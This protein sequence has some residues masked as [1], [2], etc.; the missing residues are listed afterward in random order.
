MSTLKKAFSSAVALSMVAIALPVASW[1][2]VGRTVGQA[3]VSDSGEA[4]YTIPISVPS[5]INGLTPALALAYGHRQEEGIAGVGWS[6][7]GLS[8]ISRCGKSFAQDGVSKTVELS[9][10]D[11]FCIDGNQLRL[12]FGSYGVAG[13][14]YRSEV[15]TIAR[16]TANGTAGN[17]PAWFL[18][19]DKSGLVYEYGN[20]TN[21]RIESLAAGWTTT[22]RSWAL[23]KIRD[24]QGNEIVFTYV[25]DGAPYGDYRISTVTYRSNPGQGVAAGYS[26]SFFYGTQPAGDVDVPYAAGAKV[27]DIKRLDRVDILY[28]PT[29][30]VRQY[31]LAYEVALSTAGRS[32]VTSIQECAGAPLQC[33]V[34]TDFTYQNGTSDMTALGA[35]TSSG[36]SIPAGTKALPIDINGDGRT[37]LV[38]PSSNVSGFWHYRLAN[39]TGGYDAV[40]NSGISSINHALAIPIDHNSDGREDILVPFSG[41]TWWAIHGSANPSQALL[42]QVNTSAPAVSTAGNA[43]AVDMDGDG[44][45]DLVWGE[46]VAYQV[47]SGVFVR[48]RLATGNGFATTATVIFDGDGE[49]ELAGPTLFGSGFE[50]HRGKR[51]DANG[52]GMA[53]LAINTV[54][55][56]GTHPN[57]PIWYNYTTVYLGGGAG[58]FSVYNQNPAI[59]LPIDMN[60]D[61]YTD[62]AFK[63]SIGT[64]QIALSTGK[65]FAPVGGGPDLTNYNFNLAVAMDWDGD[66]M[67]DLLIP[68]TSS[69][70]WYYFRSLG[71]SFATAVN[72]G[73]ATSSAT[74][75]FAI[76]SNGDGLD[77]IGYVT[78]AG[79]Y[80]YRA[81]SGVKPDLLA[82][83]T[84]GNGNTITFNYQPL[85]QSTYT[86]YSSATFP[87]QD[88]AGPTYVVSSAVPSTGI[89]SGTY[90]L[91]Y[92]YAGAIMNV[93]GRGLA[94]FDLKTTQDSRNGIKV[95]EYFLRDFPY[96]GRLYKRQMTQSNDTMIQEVTNTWQAIVGGTG[97]QNYHF[98]YV[99]QSLEKN[100][101]A[102]GTYNGAQLNEISTTTVVD[103]YGTPTS[104]TKVTTEM[105][106]ANGAQAGAIFTEQV[107]NS[108]ITDNVTT[109][110][111]GKVGQTDWINSHSQAYGSQITRTVTR[112]WETSSYCR[113]L[114]EVTEPAS[115]TYKVTRGVGYDAFGNVNSETVTGVNMTAR[116]TTTNWGTTGQFP[117]T[118]TNPLSQVTTLGWDAAKAVQTSTT[119]PNG[120]VVSSLYDEFGRKTRDTRVDGTYTT[121][122]L[123]A[124]TSGNSYCGTSYSR[125]KTKLR[126]LA[127]NTAGTEIR[128]DDSF[129]DKM[130]RPVQSERQTLGGAVSRVR[131]IYDTLGRVSQ[132]SAP[133]F[134]VTPA[135]NSTTTYDLLNRPTQISRPIDVGNPALQYTITDYFGLTTTTTDAE[136]KISTKVSDALGRVYRS[137]D[138][139]GYY[140]QFE[141]DAF[142]SVR[143]VSDAAGN[144]L[145]Q[146][147]Y[148][149]GIEAHRLSSDDMDMGA[150]T[151][152]P[153]ALGELVAYTDAKAQNFSATFDQLSRPLTRTEPGASAT[154]TWGTSAAAHNIGALAMISTSGH[155]ESFSYDTKGRISQ[156]TIVSDATY[157][158][159]Y[160]FDA[161]TGLLDSLQYPTSTSSYRL[162]LKYTYQY[163]MLQ[164]VSDF[165]VPAT[166]FW[167][168]NAVDARG[169]VIQQTLG[170]GLQ[171]IRGFDEVTGLPD[172]IQSGPGGSAT[173]QNL[174]LIWNKVGSLTQ[175]KDGKRSLT[176]D[177]LYD[178]LHR[179]D[180]STLNN[181][182]NL[183]LS[184][185]TVGMGNITF[186][187]DVHASATWTY[188]ATKKHAVITAGSN[189]YGYDANGNQSTRNGQTVTWTSYNYP[190]HVPNG[191][192]Y[193]DYFYD[194]NRQ[195]W[196]QVYFNGS[197]SETTIFVGGIL[198]KHT[199][200]G[201]T[202]HRHYINAGDQPVALLTRPSSGANTTQYLLLDHLGSV[203]EI[204]NSLGTLDVPENF[205]AFGERRDA[206]DWSGPPS[207][208]EE[209]AM[210]AV[211][212]RGFTFHTN[213]EGSS[214]IHM[215]G[216]IADGLTGRFL[217]PDPYVFEPQLTQSFNRYSYVRNNPLTY[218]DPSGFC[219]DALI[220]GGV[221]WSAI[222]AVG[223]YLWRKTFGRGSK[224]PP[225]T[226]CINGASGVGCYGKAIAKKLYNIASDIYGLPRLGAPPVW[227]VGNGTF[228]SGECTIVPNC[229][230]LSDELSEPVSSVVAKRAI[231]IEAVQKALAALL[232]DEDKREYGGLLY[233]NSDRSY[234]Y[235][236]ELI[237][238]SPPSECD[239][240]LGCVDAFEASD[241]VPKG[242]RIV[243]TFH[244]H[245][246][247]R[248]DVVFGRFSPD[249]LRIA[250]GQ[251]PLR[252]PIDSYVI[253]TDGRIDE[254]DSVLESI[255]TIWPRK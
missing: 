174:E 61:G 135:Y 125:V 133:S 48:Y 181:E 155:S 131:T 69:S 145:M 156:R 28:L 92:T 162:K 201:I 165:A 58:T 132:Q 87:N 33:L 130:D 149:Y 12:T 14:K 50:Q 101:E 193:H 7:S 55:D 184:Y 196:K 91:T 86:K 108:T 233:R 8:E 254:Y 224:R 49:W 60:G 222:S 10:A 247:D 194:A 76:D 53:D 67:Q 210:N 187:S 79:L 18:V 15:D 16:Y 195:R 136:G 83:A 90:T 114:T 240:A 138:H 173:L 205:A 51:F 185:D 73:L 66:G 190:S 237:R 235:T 192:K 212:Q 24:R 4:T 99:Q 226:G 81:H 59:G 204:T 157:L 223:S 29:T 54:Q 127:K 23:S 228:G 109:W 78:S 80:V 178:D 208:G 209:A 36:S 216:R 32:R 225:P 122:T 217:S 106:T 150:W 164:K 198:E 120:H 215:N 186:K 31:K 152:S 243:G 2:A 249:D 144:N 153:N 143:R 5:G 253:T 246:N 121:Y 242:A 146:A 21:S 128:Y 42:T 72:T 220:P 231:A 218:T 221:C 98:P 84:D 219:P 123:T 191:T 118:V 63:P 252:L 115:S 207:V 30:L 211:T 27:Q 9:T 102:G 45:D 11:R 183:D 34:K 239:G 234:G 203:A 39:A 94:G 251:N 202:K 65:S 168:A 103:T 17:G 213:S 74:A 229:M 245:P 232:S 25:E 6:V 47:N 176:E 22:A 19:E 88:Y 85:P 41:G 68:N 137:I 241:Q 82:T 62:I 113:L 151:Y 172:Y 158:I 44:R 159:N 116:T 171:S 244:A 189:S 179:L 227:G 117:V 166:V 111:L 206:S 129:V 1:A 255:S 177:F 230:N 163:G 214:L 124:C 26:I 139:A 147:T 182:P 3:N 37:D 167:Q 134:A 141:Y 64:M 169:N 70:T 71:E 57:E 96:R 180:N 20:S 238:G 93:N 161:T 77:D 105:S 56:R 250:Q 110:C 13:S 248:V 97:F 104:V 200:D 126:A 160:A 154:W 199:A 148:A 142:G 107:L 100:Y 170:N 188:H 236:K 119:D 35:E 75:A 197:T 46:N 112:T 140:Q 43:T 175:R 40:I 95:K 89:G 52:D 38:Y